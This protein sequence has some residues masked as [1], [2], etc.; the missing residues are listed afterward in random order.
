MRPFFLKAE[1]IS[2]KIEIEGE[3]GRISVENGA[4]LV[5]EHQPKERIYTLCQREMSLL[6][7]ANLS[8][9][10]GLELIN[11]LLHRNPDTAIKFRTY[12]DFCERTGKQIEEQIAQETR[13]I[14]STHHFDAE[15]GKATKELASELMESATP[16][17]DEAAI[18]CAMEKINA[19]RKSA[20]EQIKTGPWQIEDSEQTCYISFDDIGVKHQ[21]EHRSGD[22]AKSGV[23]VWNTVANIEAKNTSHTVTGVGMKKTFL[24]VLA[25]LLQSNLLS[26]KNLVFFTD[27]A[28]NI[29]ANISEIFSFHS[30]TVIL[31]WYHL[32]KRCQE[33]LSMSVKGKEKR[34]EI[35]QKLLRILWVGNVDEALSYLR[36]LD[37]SVLRPK[38]RIDD[39]CQYIEK[40]REHI[41]PYALR[42]ELGLRNSSNRVEKANDLVVAQRQKHNGMSWSTSGSGALA[43][44]TALIINDELHS[45]LN[46]GVLLAY[47]PLAA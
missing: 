19:T 31:D 44:I 46:D 45:W 22:N 40:H 25:Y 5:P 42:A 8:Y 36:N 12:R 4:N 30:Y 7:S 20:E 3:I 6:V 9:H 24:Y 47:Q 13:D 33:Y 29:F 21:K 35:L 41:P 27:G 43:Q 2:R 37:Q 18:Q 1:K 15:S 17:A 39:L 23:Y 11:R 14:L 26:G 10:K 16:Y 28:R 32:K 38:N 34:N